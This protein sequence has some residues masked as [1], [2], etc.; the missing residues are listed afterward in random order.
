MISIMTRDVQ[1]TVQA[2]FCGQGLDIKFRSAYL[3]TIFDSEENKVAGMSE[4]GVGLSG[5]RTAGRGRGYYYSRC[6][7]PLNIFCRLL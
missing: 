5:K 3:A 4:K 2:F 6:T 7:T 1:C